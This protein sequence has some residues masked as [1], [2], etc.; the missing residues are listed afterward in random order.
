MP[1]RSSGPSK[2]PEPLGGQAGGTREDEGGVWQLLADELAVAVQAGDVLDAVTR[3][4]PVAWGVEMVNISLLDADGRSLRLV[5]SVHT[6]DE[7]EQAY[8]TY[9]ASGP[10]PSTDALRTGRPVLLR[11]LQER[12]SRYPAF[13]R[14]ELDQQSFA[15]LPLVHRGKPLGVLGLGW[16]SEQDFAPA[17]VAELGRVAR[18]CA[19]A[20]VRCRQYEQQ[21]A[22]QESTE[23]A[24]ERLRTLYGLSTA[25]AATT[26]AEEVAVT[27]VATCLPALAATAA[28]VSELDEQG[29]VRVLAH[30]GLPWS[31]L[32]VAGERLE[33]L[34]LV[35]QMLQTG[36]PVWVESFEDRDRRFPGFPGQG[37]RQQGWANL[38]LTISDRLRG[39]V[40]FGWD[41]PRA[42]TTADREFYTEIARHVALA[43]D[44]ARLLEGSRS[45]AETLQRALLPRHVPTVPGWDLATYY[46]P[47]RE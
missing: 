13:A 45:V 21:R 12:D 22:R 41:D 38:P 2:L 30:V 29:A 26:T 3:V 44:R 20:L 32:E 11:S 5:R 9:S 43:L 1:A 14:I 31:E 37:V 17:R 23:Q 47:A 33:E 42:F 8:A 7:V 10:F 34:P 28:V 16:P 19:A 4:A 25:L 24:A 18:I 36:Q 39:M 15:V 46:R 6:P 27:L 35:R 40:A